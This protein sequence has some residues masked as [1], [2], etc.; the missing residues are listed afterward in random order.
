MARRI[1]PI[2]D[3]VLAD[4]R[5]AGKERN[6]VLSL[7]TS[8][9]RKKV[10]TAG[11]RQCLLKI[12]KRLSA[13]PATVDPALDNRL[14]VALDRAEKAKDTW[15]MSFIPSLRGQLLA[16]R[17]M[18]ASQMKTLEKVE[19]RHSPTVAAELANWYTPE[20]QR[21]ATIAAKYYRAGGTYWTR[22]ADQILDNPAFIPSKERYAKFAENKYAKKIIAAV[23]AEPKFKVGANVRVRAG[24]TSLRVVKANALGV[25]V[26][27]DARIPTSAAAGAKVYLVLFFGHPKPIFVEERWIKRG[28]V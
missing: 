9:Q 13:A 19:A 11:R 10:L 8:Y 7:Q 26:K 12:E 17:K 24:S 27:T 2:F 3:K 23:E 14:T 1:Q 18:S 22:L 4:P 20:R 15:A 28:K 16:G 21:R 25:V 5:I 6:F